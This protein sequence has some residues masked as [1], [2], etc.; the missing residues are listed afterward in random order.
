[1]RFLCVLPE[2]AATTLGW[3]SRTVS[4]SGVSR[5]CEK[6]TTQRLVVSCASRVA[7]CAAVMRACE[8]PA[9]LTVSTSTASVDPLRYAANL[10][11]PAGNADNEL[12]HLKL[13][14]K[15]PSA[16]R[17]SLIDTIIRRDQQVALDASSEAF[18]FSAAVAGFGQRL[19]GGS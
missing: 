10:L 16:H 9:R 17:S 1:M 19:R 5:L 2:I 18:R 13:R 15:L 12:A 14:Y 3:R 6:T 4:A 11:R 7:S 8:V